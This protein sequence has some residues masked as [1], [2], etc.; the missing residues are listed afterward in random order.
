MHVLQAGWHPARQPHHLAALQPPWLIPV[1]ALAICF[2]G[3]GQLQDALVHPPARARA[4]QRRQFAG[5]VAPHLQPSE[6]RER[7]RERCFRDMPKSALHAYESRKGRALRFCGAACVRHICQR[8]I[9]Q[10]VRSNTPVILAAAAPPPKI[11]R[12]LRLQRL[13]AAH[14]R[15]CRAAAQA[16]CSPPPVLLPLLLLPLLLPPGGRPMLRPGH[17]QRCPPG[18]PALPVASSPLARLPMLVAV[19][20]QRPLVLAAQWHPAAVAS[21]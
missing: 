17:V 1:A 15:P 4:H 20:A 8:C 19:A 18:A 7:S 10:A 11:P 12:A 14:L 6:I 9:W 3:A 16:R 13:P 5:L 2:H 21:S